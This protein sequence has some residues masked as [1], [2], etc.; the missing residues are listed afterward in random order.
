MSEV[1]K[2]SPELSNAINSAIDDVVCTAPSTGVSVIDVLARVREVLTPQQPDLVQLEELKLRDFVYFRM[3]AL[4]SKGYVNIC[5]EKRRFSFRTP[6]GR[7]PRESQPAIQNTPVPQ[8]VEEVV[9]TIH[10]EIDSIKIN[11]IKAVE[12]KEGEVYYS[13]RG[14]PCKVVE[15]TEEGVNMISL[16]SDSVCLVPND[17]EL[18]HENEL[19]PLS[20]LQSKVTIPPRTN[21]K[22]KVQ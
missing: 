7:D 6:T 17:L 4:R 16:I 21:V 20:F 11:R 18:I 15:K 22:E 19:I 8:K 10:E 12:A 2:P 14:I 1:F 3:A 9:Q 13:P 5:T